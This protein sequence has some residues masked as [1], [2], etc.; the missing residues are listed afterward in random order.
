MLDGI[1]PA[2]TLGRWGHN[3]SDS[4]RAV[5]TTA[6][7]EAGY[8]P[9]GKALLPRRMAVAFRDDL[10]IRYIRECCTDDEDGGCFV[11]GYL[12]TV[13]GSVHRVVRSV[14]A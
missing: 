11:F 10:S 4:A 12:F 2:P 13:R 3:C 14:G 7:V 1:P 9:D 8:L 5:L 6:A